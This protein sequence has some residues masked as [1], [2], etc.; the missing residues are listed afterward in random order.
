MAINVDNRHEMCNILDGLSKEELLVKCKELMTLKN[1]LEDELKKELQCDKAIKKK[2]TKKEH[3]QRVFDF[4]KYAT[5]RIAFKFLY[6][7]WDYQGFASQ[8]N[9]SNTIEEELFSALTKSKLIESRD[10]I[11]YSCCGRTDKGVSAYGQVIALDVRSNMPAGN[12]CLRTSTEGETV[13]HTNKELPYVQ[14]LN[15]LLPPDIR[16]V[17]YT[18]VD[19]EFDARFSCRTRVYKYYF[20]ASNLDIDLMHETAQKLVGEKDFRNFCKVDVGNDKLNHFIRNIVSFTVKRIDKTSSAHD[21]CEMEI[22]GLA[23]LWHQV[24]CMVAVLLLVGLHLEEP[25][26]IDFLLDIEICPKKPQYNMASEYPL[27]LYDCR[28][29]NV[30]W[31]YEQEF[32]EPNMNK[33]QQLL[34]KKAIQSSILRSMLD[35]LSCRT[36][37]KND[38]SFQISAILPSHRSENY[39]LLRNRSV[40]E[41]FDRH[42]KIVAA[43]RLKLEE[44]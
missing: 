5:Q 4:S 13:A 12:T 22:E 38:P 41:G 29:D 36:L 34:T 31:I 35:D 10:G 19:G 16:I 17:A 15:R 9:T 23:F 25:N 2:A 42:M 30:E 32:N 18:P 43:K 33:I 24:R 7:G 28:Y 39:K 27:V 21:M 20:P 6:L 44:E 1:K 8:E 40:C 14:I 26:A 3:K 11:N 37:M